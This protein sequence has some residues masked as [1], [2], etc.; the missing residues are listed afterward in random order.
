MRQPALGGGTD[1]SRYTYEDGRVSLVDLVGGPTTRVTY[2]GAGR[3]SAFSVHGV[4]GSHAVFD[5]TTSYEYDDSGRRA[6]E[7]TTVV[8]TPYMVGGTVHHVYDD[9]GRVVRDET[10]SEGNVA[11]RTYVYD[12]QG[13]RIAEDVSRNGGDVEHC[14]FSPPCEP[15]RFE[16]CWSSCPL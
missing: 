7:R 5:L 3:R 12:E 13:R 2:D 16:D 14:P 4:D 9:G 8:G 11:V 1:L 6:W 15:P 10:S